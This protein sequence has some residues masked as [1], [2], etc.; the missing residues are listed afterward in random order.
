MKILKRVLVAA[1]ITAALLAV[2]TQVANAYWGPGFGGWRHAY[3][4]DPAYR[5]APPQQKAYIR[6]LYLRGPGYANWHQ[7]RRWHH[8]PWW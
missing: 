1:G 6:D 3:V 4:H 7:Q 2:P 8:G 5:W